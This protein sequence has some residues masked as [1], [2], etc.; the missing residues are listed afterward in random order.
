MDWV[1]PA[2]P[3][4][5][6]WVWGFRCLPWCVQVQAHNALPLSVCATSHALSAVPSPQARQDMAQMKELAGSMAKRFSGMA[7]RWMD[8]FDRY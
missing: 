2:V 3:G 7:S 8:D 4:L 1:A 5:G 6:A